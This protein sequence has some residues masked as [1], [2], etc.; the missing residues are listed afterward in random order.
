MQLTYPEAFIKD[1]KATGEAFSPQKR[2]SST[3]KREFLYL[4]SIFVGH[5]CPP[6]S[7]SETLIVIPLYG[8]RS[9]PR[10]LY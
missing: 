7:G 3:V 10:H 4:F 1:A 2:T 6:G 5:F 8:C 9:F